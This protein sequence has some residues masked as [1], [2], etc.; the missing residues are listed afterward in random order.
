MDSKHLCIRWKNN[1]FG[2]LCVCTSFIFMVR[3]WSIYNVCNFN[4]L[5]EIILYDVYTEVYTSVKICKVNSR[6]LC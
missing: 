1:S 2:R 6:V 5:F 4:K 3:P